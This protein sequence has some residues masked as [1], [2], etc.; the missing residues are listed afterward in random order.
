MVCIGGLHAARPRG[1][2]G[3]GSACNTKD[4]RVRGN[5]GSAQS[6]KT[7]PG[8]RSQVPTYPKL[9]YTHR[10]GPSVDKGAVAGVRGQRLAVWIAQDHWVQS[11]LL[12]PN[13]PASRNGYPCVG[14]RVAHARTRAGGYSYNIWRQLCELI[15]IPVLGDRWWPQKEEQERDKA[16][17][18]FI[19]NAEENILSA[20]ML[21]VSLLGVGTVLRLERD[22]W[23]MVK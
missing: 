6:S 12:L 23:S 14:D 21:E 5:L 13:R 2:S 19:K 15:A 18:T 7:A 8:P 16:S 4:S 9:R 10:E 17:K 20:Q 11:S 1:T 22:A 3:R